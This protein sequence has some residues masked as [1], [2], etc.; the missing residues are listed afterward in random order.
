[1]IFEHAL[2]TDF[3]ANEKRLTVCLPIITEVIYGINVIFGLSETEFYH[4]SFSKLRNQTVNER[5]IKTVRPK[6]TQQN[7]W[8]LIG[9]EENWETQFS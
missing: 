1:M 6:H 9:L 3:T 4:L 8:L 5:D 7:K 2:Y